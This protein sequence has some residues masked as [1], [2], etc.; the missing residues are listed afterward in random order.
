MIINHVDDPAWRNGIVTGFFT[1]NY[2]PLAESFSSNLKAFG[3]PHVLYDVEQSA[4]EQAILLKPRI[5]ARAMNDYP[6]ATVILMDIDCVISDTLAPVLEFSGDVS[7]FVG[8]RFKRRFGNKRVR[9]RVLPSSRILVWR[10]TPHARQLLANWATLCSEHNTADPQIDD[11]QILMKAIGNTPGVA[12]HIIEQK[13]SARDP[14]YAVLDSV[15][16]H[17]SAHQVSLDRSISSRF[18]KAKRAV[19]SKIIGRPYPAPKYASDHFA[20]AMVNPDNGLKGD[21]FASIQE[22]SSTS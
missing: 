9:M 15:V 17:H 6:G 5:V 8:V 10:P 11:E 16:I 18:R 2:K 4:W 19:I 20:S 13:Y 1:P 14:Q 12:V 7:L 3:V 22:H 21:G